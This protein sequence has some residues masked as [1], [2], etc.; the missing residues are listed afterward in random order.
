MMDDR[1]RCFEQA[2]LDVVKEAS[3]YYGRKFESWGDLYAWL[4]RIDHDRILE[5]DFR[6]IE[7]WQ[8][9]YTT[10]CNGSLVEGLDVDG[11]KR[12]AERLFTIFGK[13]IDPIRD[14]AFEMPRGGEWQVRAAQ[15]MNDPRSPLN[16]GREDWELF[17]VKS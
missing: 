5:W 9:I 1:S 14:S 10:A 7:R 2:R 6:R 17:G 8:E 16:L 3:T 15:Q 13:D 12:N 11:L 4:L